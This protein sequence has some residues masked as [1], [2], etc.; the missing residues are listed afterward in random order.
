MAET[1]T[2]KELYNL[3][4]SEPL[5]TLS[6]RFGVS[7]VA[8]R[9]AC[10]RAAIPTPDRGYWA[11]KNAGKRTCHAALAERSPG[12]NDHVAIGKAGHCHYFGYYAGWSR[13]DLLGP[14]GAPPEFPEP[15]EVVQARIAKAVGHIA[16]SHKP[17]NWHPAID[18]H[19]KDDD[20][21]REKQL[22]DPYPM[23]WD[24][25]IFDTPFERRRLRIL[26][27]LFF[28]VAKMHGKASLQDREARKIGISFFQQQVVLDLDRPKRANRGTAVLS[29]ARESGDTRLCL[30]I[31]SGWGS[32]KAISSWQEDDAKKA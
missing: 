10:I 12:M 6:A 25:P 31:L 22:R 3:V 7:D 18:R 32:E 23:S 8:L 20:R 1:L 2:R 29:A 11:R 26:N 30:S 14:I 24:K 27:S 4:W 9:K 13:E 16:V 5:K 28:A 21:R 17:Q 15:I 19:L